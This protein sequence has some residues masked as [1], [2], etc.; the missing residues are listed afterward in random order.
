MPAQVLGQ[1]LLCS[2]FTSLPPLGISVVMV[3]EVILSLLSVLMTCWG[4]LS[5]YFVALSCQLPA[6]DYI[7][8]G[9]VKSRAGPTKHHLYSFP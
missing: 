8:Q 5:L 4:W 7:I 6:N 2:N 1:L 9:L 3:G